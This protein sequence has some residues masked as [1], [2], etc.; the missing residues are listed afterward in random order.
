MRVQNC[1]V[2]ILLA[3]AGDKGSLVQCGRVRNGLG[4]LLLFCLI[5]WSVVVQRSVLCGLV[6]GVRTA[7]QAEVRRAALHYQSARRQ[8][9]VGS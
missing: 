4:D 9:M 7:C 1:L 2:H 3:A 5:G 8:G 6:L